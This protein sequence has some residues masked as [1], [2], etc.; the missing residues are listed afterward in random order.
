MVS[1]HLL[2]NKITPEQKIKWKALL[3]LCKD[4]EGIG[5]TP[6]FTPELISKDNIDEIY[7]GILDDEEES[8]LDWLSDIENGIR[9]SG[10]DTGIECEWSNH[11]ESKSVA[12]EMPDGSWVGWTCWYG[13]GKHGEPESIDWMDSAYD[14]TVREETQIVRVFERK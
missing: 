10:V 3:S 4:I 8:Y 11:Y 9:L 1:Q 12:A 2:R 7:D 13:G 14:V 5:H 6:P